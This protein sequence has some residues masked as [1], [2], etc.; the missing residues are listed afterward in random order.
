MNVTH[1]P[2][3]ILRL[4]TKRSALAALEIIGKITEADMAWMTGQVDHAFE[5]HDRIDLMVIMTNFDGAEAAAVLNGEAAGASLKSLHHL[6]KYA[7]V[8]APGWARAMIE[9]MGSILPVKAMTFDK[10]DE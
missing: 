5:L 2:R 4:E 3:A 7:V 8:G 9:T 10:G 1:A 6:R